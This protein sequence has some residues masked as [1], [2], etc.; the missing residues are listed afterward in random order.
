MKKS[1]IKVMM[2]GEIGVG[3]TSIVRRLMFNTFDTAYKATIGVDIYSFLLEGRKSHL[4]L[5]LELLIW[6]IDGD[7]GPGI[8]NHIYLKGAGA[9]CIVSDAT[10]RVTYRT[11]L[12]L[13][14]GFGQN[15]PGRPAV[16]IV[17]KIDLLPGDRPLGFEANSAAGLDILWAS[18]ATGHQ[19]FDAFAKLG[20]RCATCGY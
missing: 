17:N 10:R 2:L 12:G 20:R 15:L 9:A 18:A 6:D 8:F 14:E 4:D 13:A 5:E 11:A 3:K 19:V 16:L 7:L 1:T